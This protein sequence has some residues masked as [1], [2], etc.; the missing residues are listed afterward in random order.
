[1]NATVSGMSDQ[2]S[3]NSTASAQSSCVGQLLI[4][5]PVPLYTFR[6]ELFVE[7]QAINGLRLWSHH[8]SEVIAMMPV[9]EGPPPV[10]W[11]PVSDHAEALN[12][13]RFECLPTAYRPDQF[14]RVLRST[15]RRIGALIREA[16]YLSF[17][18]GGL[19][20]D[21]G[22]VA[23]LEA[24][25]QGRRFAVWTDRVESEVVRQDLK[26]THWRNRL[27]ARLT[28]RPMVWLERHVIRKAQL[29]LFHGM[30]T[31][32]AYSPYSANPHMV[33]DI[34]INAD[35]HIPTDMLAQK[36]ATVDRNPLRIVY[37]GRADAMKGPLDW[38]AVLERL[39]VMGIDF[40][41]TWLGNG[42]ELAAMRARI[43]RAGLEDR[44][45][46]PGFVTD[47]DQ[48]LKTLREAQLFLFCHKT[49]ESPRCLIEAL[50]NATPIVGYG[51]AY[52]QDLISAHSG[53]VLV[54]M[55]DIE[56]LAQA[57][58]DLA[59]DRTRLAELI[60]SARADGLPFTDEKVFEHRSHL[61]KEQL[62][63]S[64]PSYKRFHARWGEKLAN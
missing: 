28:Y 8:F 57:V 63:P 33:H 61:I 22:A 49:P 32:N 21:W 31:F 54:P 13:V 53:G 37:A 56:A 62:A 36:V 44:V 58:G 14:L 41:A 7:S 6:G 46:L 18:I 51:G 52:A 34:H 20:G 50:C 24:H 47:R 15:R 10:G 5:A 2:S 25:R 60:T 23:A 12:S 27:R 11:L 42:D 48:V 16:E 38:V 26:D 17:A 30:E 29:G 1:M 43:S 39:K 64:A 35:D 3:S 55:N 59:A 45:E 9:R 40:R 4:F 19:F